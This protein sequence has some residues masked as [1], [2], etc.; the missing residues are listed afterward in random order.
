MNAAFRRDRDGP[1]ASCQSCVMG[2]DGRPSHA[3]ADST[4]S[5]LL[6]HALYAEGLRNVVAGASALEIRRALDEGAMLVIEALRAAA[7]PV[8]TRQDT[9][10]IGATTAVTTSGGPSRGGARRAG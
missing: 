2:A 9:A 7:R 3:T 10:Q 6:A 5:T 4:T 8:K 1:A